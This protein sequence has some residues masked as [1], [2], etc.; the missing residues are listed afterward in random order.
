MVGKEDVIPRSRSPVSLQLHQQPG[1]IS[2]SLH[3]EAAVSKMVVM[4]TPRAA[5]SGQRLSLGVLG[6]IQ[7]MGASDHYGR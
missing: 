4:L 6:T 1:A 3:F 7:V 5:C 2:S